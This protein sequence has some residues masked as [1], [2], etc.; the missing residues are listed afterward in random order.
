MGGT[1]IER[2]CVMKLDRLPGTTIEIDFMKDFSAKEIIEPIFLAGG[3]VLSQVAQL[4]GLNPHVVQN[5]VKRKFVSPPVSKKYSKDQFCRIVIINLLKDSLPLESISK[6]ISYVNGRLDDTADDIICDSLLYYYFTDVIKEISKEHG[7]DLINLD[8]V[9][10]KVL[11]NEELKHEHKNK[12]FQVLKIMAVAYVS[13]RLKNLAD[14]YIEG[15]DIM[16][17]I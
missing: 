15:L 7:F 10:K 17:G 4:T 9:I 1:R 12:V 8:D 16:E 3:L 11:Q 14:I 13:A 5:W 2:G 6:L